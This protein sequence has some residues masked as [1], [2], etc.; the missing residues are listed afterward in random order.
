MSNQGVDTLAGLGTAIN[1]SSGQANELS[2]IEEQPD[3]EDAAE[4]N[5]SKNLLGDIQPTV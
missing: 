1:D 4:P 2:R 5:S 3:A